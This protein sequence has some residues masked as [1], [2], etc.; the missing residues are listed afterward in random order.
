MQ[1]TIPEATSID[2]HTDGLS[3]LSHISNH[4][5]YTSVLLNIETGPNLSESISLMENSCQ[6]ETLKI[7]NI[8]LCV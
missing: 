1:T 2:K 5:Q 4:L 7:E 6:T 3:I 8:P